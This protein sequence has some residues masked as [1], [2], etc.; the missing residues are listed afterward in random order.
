MQGKGRIKIT[1]DGPY[2][3]SGGVPLTRKVIEDDDDGYPVRWRLVESYPVKERY[4]LCRCGYS[5]SKPY[6]DGSHVGKEFARDETKDRESYLE[7]V[8]V[9]DG[10][11]LKLTDNK[12]L[13]VGAGFCTRAGNV[14][15]LTTNSDTPQYREAAIQEAQDCPSGRLVEWDKEGVALEPKFEPSIAATEDQYGELGPLWVMGGVEVESADGFLY[16]VRNRVTLCRCGQSKR[17]PFCDG[18]HIQDDKES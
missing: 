14:W 11:E 4:A 15:N 9:Y 12:N 2:L 7:G 3:I 1:R 13:C 18:S 16:E 10:P 8:K 17:M 5:T 6:C